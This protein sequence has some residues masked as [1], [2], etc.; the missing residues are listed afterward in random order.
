VTR[1]SLVIPNLNSGKVLERAI[2]SILKQKYPAVQL[3]LADGGSSDQS[4]EVIERHRTL[5][6]P[7]IQEPDSGQ[8][9]ALNKGF[10][11][12]GGDVFGW[13]C[14][15]DQLLPGA[16]HEVASIFE[17][18]PE[19]DVV[20]GASQHVYADGSRQPIHV[21]PD[22]WDQM[23]VRNVFNQ[24]SVFWRAKLHR[25]LGPLDE[26]YHLAFDWEFWCR[27]QNA[28]ASLRIS[29]K[30]LSR[31]HF[32]A[33]NK[34][35]VGGRRHVDE[36]FRIISRYGPFRGRLAY[37]YRFLYLH[38]DLKGCMDHP[39]RGSRPRMLAYHLTWQGL[40]LAIGPKWLRLY[41]LN[42]ASKQER[43]IRWWKD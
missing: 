36:A 29:K 14:A 22:A 16:L 32:S 8:A 15:D 3:I 35:S 18:H 41:N 10:A 4:L 23:R 20:A 38:F 28:G 7:L 37:A 30:T 42:F 5:F 33:E 31:Y 24:P 39:P 2:Q 13:L 26:S 19:T 6:Q 12:A 1:F 11:H 9:D 43:G 17:R 25:R 27:M 40:R 34:T 21:P